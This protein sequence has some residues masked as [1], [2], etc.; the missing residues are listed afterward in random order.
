ME[1]ELGYV[2]K[3]GQA[4]EKKSGFTNPDEAKKFVTQ[5]GVDALA[6]AIGSAHGFYKAEPNLDLDRLSKIDEITPAAL[7]LHGSS[8][9]PDLQIQKSI[10]LGIRKINLATEIKDVFMNTLQEDLK[11]NDEID[12][13]K[14][15]P[16]AIEKVNQLVQKKL[17][18]INQQQT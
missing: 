9:I 12:L 7:V 13:R 8:G 2:A 3:L 1:A 4:Q 6:V 10:R 18:M 5:T 11:N 17:T 15:F 16:S 14:I